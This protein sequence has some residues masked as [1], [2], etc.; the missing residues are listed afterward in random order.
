MRAGFEAGAGC[1]HGGRR[2]S[3]QP[4][5]YLDARPIALSA[6]ELLVYVCMCVNVYVHVCTHAC[7][8]VHVH[9]CAGGPVHACAFVCLAHSG[10]MRSESHRL[11]GPQ[12][13]AGV[14]AVG[15][16]FDDGIA[17]RQSHAKG[18]S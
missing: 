6:Y 5:Q 7:M 1:I 2:A 18:C 4:R 11:T 3:K 14:G 17:M 8:Y 16:E 12:P 10:S 9:V 13:I 15:D